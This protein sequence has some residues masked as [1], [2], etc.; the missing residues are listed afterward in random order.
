MDNC[1]HLTLRK[2][3]TPNHDYTLWSRRWNCSRILP[4]S[5][6]LYSTSFRGGDRGRVGESEQVHGTMK[7]HVN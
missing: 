7:L 2:E 1:T 5:T 6:H 4:E 3:L